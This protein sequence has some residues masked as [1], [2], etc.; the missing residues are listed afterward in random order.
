MNGGSLTA[1]NII[2]LVQGAFLGCAL[3]ALG[4]EKGHQLTFSLTAPAY[5]LEERAEDYIDLHR[6]EVGLLGW[7]RQEHWEGLEESVGEAR[8]VWAE[9]FLDSQEAPGEG[10]EMWVRRD[11]LKTCSPNDA[12]GWVSWV[13]AHFPVEDVE[14]IPADNCIAMPS[15]AKLVWTCPNFDFQE[16]VGGESRFSGGTLNSVSFEDDFNDDKKVEVIFP[17]IGNPSN[18]PLAYGGGEPDLMERIEDAAAAMLRELGIAPARP[19]ARSQGV[20]AQ[21]VLGAP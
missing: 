16:S 3:K 8:F 5:G 2:K 15:T 12:T 4:W 9:R 18:S 20:K 11:A 17:Y 13:R 6:I 14:D 10:G 1:R 21:V 7:E 19:L